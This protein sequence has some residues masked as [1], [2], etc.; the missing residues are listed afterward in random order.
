[1]DKWNKEILDK[2][3]REYDVGIL[4]FMPPTDEAM[5]G[6]RL[7][8]SSLFIDTNIKLKVGNNSFSFAYLDN[9]EAFAYGK[10]SSRYLLTIT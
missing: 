10:S 6:I 7:K 9:N 4:G 1:M 5:T 8:G 2:Y 3:S